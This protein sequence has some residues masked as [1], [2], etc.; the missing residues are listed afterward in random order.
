MLERQGNFDA[1]LVDLNAVVA[2]DPTDEIRHG[3]VIQSEN[4]V[5]VSALLSCAGFFAR[6]ELIAK[7]Q[8]DA[9]G[10]SR[11]ADRQQA[12]SLSLVALFLAT[13]LTPELRQGAQAVELAKL[14]SELTQFKERRIL[15]TLA[16]AYAETRYFDKAVETEKQALTLAVNEQQT[17]RCQARLELYAQKM[18][19]REVF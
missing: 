6:R 7:A 10:A 17:S 3:L 14:A 15:E 2:L 9:A 16:A 1:A 12:G 18:P 11:I 5:R 8:A 4:E 13:S 19:F